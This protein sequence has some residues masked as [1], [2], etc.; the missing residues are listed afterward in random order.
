MGHE[1]SG[2][3][4]GLNKY[5]EERKGVLAQK[6]ESGTGSDGEQEGHPIFGFV[7]RIQDAGSA[8]FEKRTGPNDSVMRKGVVEGDPDEDRPDDTD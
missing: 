1:E 6:P 7:N 4:G 8:F 5:I 2:E 3:Q